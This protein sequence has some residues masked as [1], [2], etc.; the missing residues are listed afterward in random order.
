VYDEF[1]SG[2]KNGVLKYELSIKEVT[3]NVWARRLGQEMKKKWCL[4]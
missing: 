1:I 3:R 2:V 4:K